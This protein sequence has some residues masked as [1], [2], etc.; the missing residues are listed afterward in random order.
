MTPNFIMFG[1]EIDFT[2]D[3]PTHNNSPPLNDRNF[4]PVARSEALQT[5]FDDVQ[6]RLLQAYEKSK[7]VYD[8]RRR[9][10]RFQLHQKVWKRNYVLSDATKQFTSK[11]APKY[12]GPYTINKIL[13]PWTYELVD[14]N[15]HNIGVWHAKDLKAHPPDDSS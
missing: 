11:L 13:S 4:D 3:N 6:K 7:R 14:D 12:V 8:L 2:K 5:V 15:R 9:D 1:R 10:E